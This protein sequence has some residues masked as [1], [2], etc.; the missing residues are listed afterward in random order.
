MPAKDKYHDIVTRALERDKW[1]VN[2]EQVLLSIGGR[3][4]LIDIEASHEGQ[5]PIVLIEVKGFENMRSPID[6]LEAAVGQ[7]VLYRAILEATSNEKPLY[8]AVPIAAY[9][10]IFNEPV[11]KVAIDRLKLK[12]LIFNPLL[13]E[14]VEWIH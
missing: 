5:Y 13:G 10:T 4:L 12:L 11:G 6:Y 9:V 8:M 2:E 3:R 14:I 7:Y 1:T